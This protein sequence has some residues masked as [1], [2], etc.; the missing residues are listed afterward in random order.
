MK[1][2]LFGAGLALSVLFLV[3]FP[4]TRNAEEQKEVLYTS[5]S[6]ELRIERNGE[7]AWVISTK[8]PGQRAE[9]PPLEAISPFY[10]ELYASLNEEWISGLRHGG[11]CLGDG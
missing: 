7:K 8:N 10:D 1:E 4:A 6:G 5:P 11:S 3:T 2:N 9:L